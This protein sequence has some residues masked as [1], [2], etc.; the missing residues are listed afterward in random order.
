MKERVMNNLV[1]HVDYFMIPITKKLQE[2]LGTLKT[3][4]RSRTHRIEVISTRLLITV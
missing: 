1:N 2:D 3:S 4:Q